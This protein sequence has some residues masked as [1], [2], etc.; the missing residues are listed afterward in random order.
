MIFK[1]NPSFIIL[2][3]LSFYIVINPMSSMILEDILFTRTEGCDLDIVREGYKITD[4]RLDHFELVGNGRVKYVT[5][6]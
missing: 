4:R 2:F 1:G 3:F 6:K 5:T